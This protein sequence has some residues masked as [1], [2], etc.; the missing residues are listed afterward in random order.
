MAKLFQSDLT[1]AIFVATYSSCKDCWGWGQAFRI[2]WKRTSRAA[3]F[4]ARCLRIWAL[5]DSQLPPHRISHLCQWRSS[6]TNQRVYQI[7]VYWND[8]LLKYIR[9][10]IF[11]QY[12]WKMYCLKYTIP[13]LSILPALKVEPFWHYKWSGDWVEFIEDVT[14]RWC[15]NT[16]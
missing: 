16:S 6:S 9:H 11:F 5:R 14:S 8:L 1:S 13:T 2:Y 15:Q 7:L 4:W 10:E 12:S 3:N